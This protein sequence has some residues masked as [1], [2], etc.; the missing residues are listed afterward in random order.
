MPIFLHSVF[1]YQVPVILQFF[2]PSAV[3]FQFCMPSAGNSSVFPEKFKPHFATFGNYMLLETLAN[4]L[5]LLLMT[6]K[7]DMV[8]ANI[9]K[10]IFTC[11]TWQKKYN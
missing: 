9:L 1:A 4:T 10:N 5:K 2:F 8:L 3:I 11:K 6:L 7:E